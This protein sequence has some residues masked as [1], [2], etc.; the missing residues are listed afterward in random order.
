MIRVGWACVLAAGALSVAAFTAPAQSSDASEAE[1]LRKE[2]QQLKEDYDQRIRKLEE[3]LHQLETAPPPRTNA[4]VPSPKIEP[5]S[6]PQAAGP[7]T[8]AI[9]AAR[10]FADEQ[11]QDT[12]ES[13]QRAIY[14]ESHPITER[15][16]QVLQ[17]FVDIHGYIRAGYGRNNEGGTQVGFQAP[18]ALSKYRLGNEAENYAELT[19]GKN[20]YVP[21]LFKLDGQTRPDG[22][23][24]GP[25]ARVQ[26]TI[27]VYNPYQD[28][29]SSSSTQYG[30]PEA[31]AEIGNVIPSQPS[32][33]FWAGSR[34]YRRQ[35][36]HISDFFY[37]NMSGS[38]GGVE[39]YEVPFGKLALAWIGSGT[40]SGFSDLPEPDADNKAGFTKGNLDLRLYDVPVP[41]GKGEV[42]VVLARSDSG[43][44]AL[45]NSA[46]STE[47]A[48][49]TAVHTWEKFLSEDGVNKFSLQYGTAAAKT[50]TAGFETYTVNNDVFIRPDD[51][52]SWRFRA[53]E[54]FVADLNEHFAIGPELLYQ[55]TDYAGHGG[56]VQWASVG[57]RPIVFFNRNIS[58]AFEG[59]FDWVQDDST[60][61]SGGLYKLT[62]A[63][64]V[65]L[66][67]KFMSRPVIRAFITFAQWSEDFE[68]QV[69]GNDYR[70][71]TTG[72]TY[73]VQM[74]SWW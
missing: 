20:F 51:R 11:F 7:S 50:F 3:R 26:T 12:T 66:G 58:L 14:M 35:D 21:E 10:K 23:P 8:N 61:T 31:F 54:H 73:G 6:P 74:E 13:R 33:K 27:S 28:Q 30:L 62:L 24:S 48:A 9:A 43:K 29:L 67:N 42:G 49:I 37:Y 22:T 44:D 60:A 64:Q 47:G 72:F 40:T 52:D 69:G 2:L 1:Q 55:Y 36:I 57:V 63:P 19:L 70:D 59:G 56:R 17:D 15:V 38:G 25:I 18:G 68:G 71:A 41:L 46:P 16:E 5:A 53:T 39:D 34:Y 45:G 32:L 65:S 4:P